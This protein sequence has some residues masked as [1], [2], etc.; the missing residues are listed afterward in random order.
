MYQ[1]SKFTPE[2]ILALNSGP[3]HYRT[4]FDADYSRHSEN[5]KSKG[6]MIYP[7]GNPNSIIP[8]GSQRPTSAHYLSRYEKD[9]HKRS[10]SIDVD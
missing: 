3:D 4:S 7:V 9:Y 6:D 2:R 5:S 1:E 8:C 10:G